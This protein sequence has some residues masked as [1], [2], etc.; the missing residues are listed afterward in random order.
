MHMAPGRVA[1]TLDSLV[2][3]MFGI[4]Y[5]RRC[6]TDVKV[7]EWAFSIITVSVISA[8]QERDTQRELLTPLHYTQGLDHICT[9]EIGREE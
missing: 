2:N 5:L 9:S 6:E 3:P 8:K 4:V 1:A 7:A